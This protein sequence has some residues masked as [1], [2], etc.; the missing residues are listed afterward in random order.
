VAGFNVYGTAG[1]QLATRTYMDF[2][3]MEAEINFLTFMPEEQ[4]LPLFRYWYRGTDKAEKL[5]E[6]LAQQSNGA[7]RVP[8][9][10]YRTQDVKKEFFVFAHRHLGNAQPYIDTLNLCREFPDICA[11]LKQ[12]P[13]THAIEEAL[14]PISDIG[15]K[16][17]EVF[18]NVTFVRVI[19]DNT[20]EHDRVYTFVRNRAYLN[21]TELVPSEKLRVKDEDSIDVLN[22][23][24]GAYPNFFI[25]LRLEDLDDFVNEYL[26]VTNFADYDRLLEKYGVRRS[27]PWFWQYA[28]WFYDKYRHEDPVYAGVFD[29]NRYQNR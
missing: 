28:D 16:I 7:P 10:P 29:L 17:T 23:F 27:N 18:P 21:N 9:L 6:F 8:N 24:V 1:H 14:R 5:E 3:R 11:S 19:V 2:L 4:R 26:A 12:D 22:G 15:G 20:V 25:V 13:T